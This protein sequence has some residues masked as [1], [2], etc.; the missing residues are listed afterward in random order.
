MMVPCFEDLLCAVL[1]YLCV[2]AVK[3]WL[4]KLT[5]RAPRYASDGR[6]LKQDVR[7]DFSFHS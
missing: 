1:Y 6:E 3:I 4:H 7:Q 5:A 2:S